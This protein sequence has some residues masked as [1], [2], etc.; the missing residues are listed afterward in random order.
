MPIVGLSV[1]ERTEE[2][3]R[4]CMSRWA[5]VSSQSKGRER[6]EPP[7]PLRTVFQVDRD[8]ILFSAAFRRLADKTHCF[9]PERD[10]P[11]GS[12]FR[13]RL[14]HTLTVA[15]IGRTVARGLRANE[16]LVEAIAL[17]ADLGGTPYGYSGEEA[18]ASILRVGDAG[19]TAGRCYDAGRGA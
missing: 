14:S 11:G 1:R 7:D 15:Q 17:G 8:R 19:F 13:T 12:P 9:I 18:L 10:A 6:P 16:D 2:L 5:T 3:E 4:S